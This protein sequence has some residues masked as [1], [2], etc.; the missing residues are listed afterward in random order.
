M[1]IRKKIR[2]LASY[3]L[4][5]MLT[6]VKQGEVVSHSHKVLSSLL[7][8]RQYSQIQHLRK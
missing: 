7:L 8:L 5:M 6:K 1:G 2:F 3:L 4:K